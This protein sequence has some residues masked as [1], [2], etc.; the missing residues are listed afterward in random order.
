MD[1]NKPVL[2]KKQAKAMESIQLMLE[3]ASY[4]PWQSKADV[5]D[6][7]LRRLDFHAERSAADTISDD[8]FIKALYIGYEVEETPEDKVREVYR[9]AKEVEISMRTEKFQMKWEGV[10]QGV[11]ETLKALGITIEGVND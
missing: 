10:Q 4:H 1:T 2:T 7:K 11:K 9:T 8:D 6:F 5:V 3:M